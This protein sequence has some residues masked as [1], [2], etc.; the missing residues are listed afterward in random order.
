VNKR[1]FGVVVNV[2]DTVPKSCVFEH[3]IGD[4]LLKAV[5]LHAT[6]AIG[7]EQV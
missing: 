7:G 6:E 2:L 4:G 1:R 5:P 3:G